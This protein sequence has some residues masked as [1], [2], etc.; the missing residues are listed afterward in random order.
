MLIFGA[1]QAKTERQQSKPNL[2][3]SRLRVKGNETP[4][5]E[6]INRTLAMERKRKEEKS[7]AQ[8]DYELQKLW[9]VRPGFHHIK[10]I[11]SSLNFSMHSV[12][13]LLF[14]GEK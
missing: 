5:K 4:W 8:V 10:T 6:S 3:M 2:S 11:F 14:S 12:C 13:Y 7:I 1:S 9:Q